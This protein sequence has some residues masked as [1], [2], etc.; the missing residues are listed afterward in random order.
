MLLDAII[1]PSDADYINTF[2]EERVEQLF[3]LADL[4]ERLSLRLDLSTG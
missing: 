4:A 3:N 1:R 2:F